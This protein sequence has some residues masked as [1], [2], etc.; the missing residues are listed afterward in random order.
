[1][2]RTILVTGAAGF[3]G[4]HL[5]QALCALGDRVLGLDNLNACYDPAIKERNLRDITHDSFTF[6]RADCRDAQALQRIFSSHPVTHVV[7]LAAWAGVRPSIEQ[8][9]VYFDNNVQGTICLLEAARAQGVRR[10]V[11]ASSSSVYGNNQKIPFAE[12]DT[13]D[14]PV[15]PYA[16]SKKAMEVAAHVWHALYGMEMTL[17]RFFTVYG[18]RQRPDLAI[19][20]FTRLAEQGQVI[21]Q[22]GDG[23]SERDY[24]YVGDVCH[25][26]V[27]SLDCIRGYEIY[28]LGSD[29]PVALSK[30]LSTLENALGYALR[31]EQVP[32][33]PGDVKATWADMR[34]ARAA[35]SMPPPYPFQ[36]GIDEF[37][38]WYR[39]GN[40]KDE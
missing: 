4:S 18:P 26:I 23:R 29:R 33:Q 1:M 37:V 5:V 2:T 40:R 30:L 3:I 7:H 21:R 16:A 15:S 31:I 35:F 19:H 6:Y 39:S 8:P 9:S 12:E 14:Y 34:K 13:V 22:F 10:L 38:A 28:N 27:S 24:S 17:L 32:D 11:L 36:Q 20:A 25:G